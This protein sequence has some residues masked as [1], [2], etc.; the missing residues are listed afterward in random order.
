MIASNGMI[1][2]AVVTTCRRPAERAPMTFTPVSRTTKPTVTNA[3]AP[4]TSAIH[5][6]SLLR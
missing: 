3:D 6:N 5:G 2:S 4:C 1:L